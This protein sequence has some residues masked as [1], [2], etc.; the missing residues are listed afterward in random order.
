MIIPLGIMIDFEDIRRRTTNIQEYIDKLPDKDRDI[1][2]EAYE[3]YSLN[4]E[5]TNELRDILKDLK[6]VIFSAP[7]CGDCKRAMPILLHLE[8]DYGLD[9][10][11][12]GEI[13]TDPLNKNVQWRV[14]PSPPE[15][16]EWG[17]T[18]IPWFEFFDSDGNKI[19]TLIEKP[20]VKETL[21][22]EMLYILKNK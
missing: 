15:I 10:M 11:V 9:A 17:A 19:A 20:H 14:P 3:E 5:A 4:K 13:K 21:E 18:A 12:F 1:V 6:V 2:L 22:E 16:N 7:W 8:K